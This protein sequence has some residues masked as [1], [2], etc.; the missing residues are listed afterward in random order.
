MPRMA[1]KNSDYGRDDCA[2]GARM[3][4]HKPLAGE[5]GSA[6]PNLPCLLACSP[7]ASLGGSLRQP[8]PPVFGGLFWRHGGASLASVCWEPAEGAR[9]PAET[10]EAAILRALQLLCGIPFPPLTRPSRLQSHTA[11]AIYWEELPTTKGLKKAAKRFTRHPRNLT[12][13]SKIWM[14]FCS[15]PWCV[16]Q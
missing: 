7:R 16:R 11:S 6:G 14:R 8:L 4:W 12:M 1:Q 15:T 2:H 3:W 10:H 13:R 9:T 5:T